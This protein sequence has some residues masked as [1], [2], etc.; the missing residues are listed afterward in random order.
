MAVHTNREEPDEHG[1]SFVRLKIARLGVNQEYAQFVYESLVKI[2]QLL[3]TT[4]KQIN[5]L[6]EHRNV[7]LYDRA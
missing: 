2:E 3:L 4:R 6:W 5:A 1:F 7:L